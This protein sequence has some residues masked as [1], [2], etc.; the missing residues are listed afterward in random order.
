MTGGGDV[1]AIIRQYPDRGRSYVT[2]SPS[3]ALAH[4]TPDA[5]VRLLPPDQMDLS[6]R[7]PLS[8]QQQ[9]TRPSPMEVRLKPFVSKEYKVLSPDDAEGLRLLPS[10]CREVQLVPSSAGESRPSRCSPAYAHAPSSVHG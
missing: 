8:L 6:S 2:L 3:E 1:A 7:P 10:S 4:V 9:P 5:E